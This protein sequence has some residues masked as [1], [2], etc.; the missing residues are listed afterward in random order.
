MSPRFRRFT[1][2]LS[3][4]VAFAFASGAHAQATR[5]WVSGVGDDLNPCSR[6]APCKTFAGA[7]SKTAANG[8]ISVL[9]PGGFGAVTITKSIAIVADGAEGGILAA[10]TN[11]IVVNGAGVSVTLRGLHIEGAG[12]GLNGIR[13]LNGSS[14]HIENCTFQGFTQVGISIESTA[15]SEVYIV[16]T[17]VRRNNGGSG[18]GILFKPAAT[19]AVV[20]LLDRVS[21][22]DNRYGLRVEDRST[23]TVTNSTASGSTTNGFVTVAASAAVELNLESSVASSNLNAGIRSEGITSIIRISNM[24]STDNGV[25]LQAVGTGQIRS[26]GN[27][28][29]EG[30]TTD[31]APTITV[32]EV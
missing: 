17:Q 30:N 29:V 25:G 14:L 27:N 22:N 26:F 18:G 6:T 2:G 15:P 23:V 3:V 1:V 11:G 19:G 31:G 4:A 28:R 5:T 24:V 12:T 16:N 20:G 8:E 32:G 7:I 10:G 13:F 21:I 9:D